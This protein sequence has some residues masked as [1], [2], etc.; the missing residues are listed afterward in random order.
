MEFDTWLVIWG[1]CELDAGGLESFFDGDQSANL[2]EW[3][4]VHDFHS[5][6]RGAAYPGALR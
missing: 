6:D 5:L 2:S 3:N 1:A 4:T